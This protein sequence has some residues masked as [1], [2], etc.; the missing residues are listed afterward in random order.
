MTQTIYDSTPNPIDPEGDLTPEH[1]KRWNEESRLLELNPVK[2]PE[3]FLN[4]DPEH[5]KKH[6]L[7][8]CSDDEL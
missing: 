8:P 6:K 5:F 3:N 1:I 2:M 4:W 7:A